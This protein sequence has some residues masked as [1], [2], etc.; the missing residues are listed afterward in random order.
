MLTLWLLS[1][2]YTLADLGTSGSVT[3]ETV[4]SRLAMSLLV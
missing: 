2:L 1:V 4:L 3:P